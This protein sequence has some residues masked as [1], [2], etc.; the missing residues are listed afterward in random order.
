VKTV[1]FVFAAISASTGATSTQVGQSR[2]T[3]ATRPEG[4]AGRAGA[5]VMQ[6]SSAARACARRGRR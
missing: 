6:T 2:F 1:S 5:D 4:S 3:N